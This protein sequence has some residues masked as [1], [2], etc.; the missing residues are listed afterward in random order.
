[1]KTKK[2][3]VTFHGVGEPHPWCVADEKPFWLT[4]AQ[5]E[6]LVPK[7]IRACNLADRELVIT[8]DDGNISDLNIATPAL[9]KNG[10]KALFF[11]CCNFSERTGYLNFEQMAQ[12]QN[13]GMAI[14][15]H[16]NNHVDWRR[17]SDID[18][19]AE[20]HGAFSELN[21]RLGNQ[22]E[23]IAIPFGSYDRRVVKLLKQSTAK[24]IFSS[25]RDVPNKSDLLTPRFTVTWDWDD[26][27]IDLA[28]AHGSST[29]PRLK[30]RLIQFAKRW[31]N[32]PTA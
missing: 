8:F 9:Q 32:S 29:L 16:G 18:L 26:E 28:L 27:K 20:I 5:F 11:V 19:E 4:I 21:R 7:L 25:D 15:S 24:S 12:L 2:F 1:M 31:R 22:I 17:C 14:G 3:V 30:R 23:A 13:A 6:T 10:V